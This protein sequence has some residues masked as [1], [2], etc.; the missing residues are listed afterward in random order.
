MIFRE[1]GKNGDS[2]IITSQKELTNYHNRKEDEANRR[3]LYE[4]LSALISGCSSSRKSTFGTQETMNYMDPLDSPT[5]DSSDFRKAMMS[6]TSIN[7]SAPIA[8]QAS[9]FVSETELY[10]DDDLY[11]G[12]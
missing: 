9:K 7:S 6:P 2:V 12:P 8:F 5:S 3:Y 4:T 10:M 11:E 1:D